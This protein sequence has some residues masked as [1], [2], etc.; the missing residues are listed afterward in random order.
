M[1]YY[2]LVIRVW[3]IHTVTKQSVYLYT[4]HSVNLN[5]SHTIS[6]TNLLHYWII[7]IP[8]HY[9]DQGLVNHT[10][11]K[12]S[13]YLY[14]IQSV[15]LKQSHTVSCT[16]LLHYWIITIL[17]HYSDQGLVESHIYQTVCLSIHNSFSKSKAVTHR[18]LY[19]PATLLNY[20][21]SRPLQWSVSVWITQLPNRMYISTPFIQ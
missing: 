16:K 14:N 9:S 18:Q 21:N 1:N 11:T 12:T 4:I 17:V 8:L 2:N 13:F 5:Q 19:Y 3:W 7:T 10:F 20:Y 6:C 15:N